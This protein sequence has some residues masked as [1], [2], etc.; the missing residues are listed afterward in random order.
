MKETHSTRKKEFIELLSPHRDSLYRFCMHVIWDKN[1]AEDVLQ[2][3]ILHAYKNFDN[4]QPGT[5]FKAWLFRFVI[6]KI[7]DCNK[8]LKKDLQHVIPCQEWDI[9]EHLEKEEAYASILEN[10]SVFFEK[11]DDR[12]KDALLS[13]TSTERMVFLLKSVE[14]FTYKEIAQFLEIPIGTVMSHLFRSR[15]KLGEL[16]AG[17]ARK[18]GF[19]R[20]TP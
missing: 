20:P 3:A 14:G 5:N 7:F 15:G 19:V 12:I 16:L 6:N 10:P 9:I 11:V 1:S 17:Y 8:R 18:M 13:L 2:E 4:F